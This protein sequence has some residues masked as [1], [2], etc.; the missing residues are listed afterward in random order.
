M[1]ETEKMK[2]C[3]S[4][5][6]NTEKEGRIMQNKGIV[7]AT[8]MAFIFLSS[9]ASKIESIRIGYVGPL[10]GSVAL[11]GSE[12]VKGATLAVEQI[13]AAGG[14]LGRSLRLYAADDK[15]NPAESVSAT[16]KIITRDRVV[17]TIGHGCSSAALAAMPINQQERFHMSLR[18][19]R[20]R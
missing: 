1:I 20:T 18:P 19:Q 4:K 2:V 6:R 8:L 16:R 5:E 11:V 13:N 15:C 14:L 9:C 10:A 17:A 12:G 3:R 7:T